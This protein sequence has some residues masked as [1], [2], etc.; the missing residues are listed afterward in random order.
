MTVS[1]RLMRLSNRSLMA[2]IF[3]FSMSTTCLYFIYVAPGIDYPDGN[4][5]SEYIAQPT[6][7]LPE[8]FT[9]AQNLPCP[10]RLPSMS[11]STSS[12]RRIYFK[13][14]TDAMNSIYYT[15][16]YL[17][18]NEFFGGVSGLTVEQFLKINGFPNAF[19]GWG[20]EDDDLWNRVHYAGFNVTRP[21]GDI[22]KYKSIPHHHRGEV[23]FLGR[24]KLLRYSKERQHLD[25]LNNLQ[26]SPEISLSSLYKNITV[27]LNPE[28]AP[29][30]EY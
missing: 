3:F 29:I 30:A 15:E 4:N 13:H 25:G 12:H 24:Y 19:W 17:P 8:N 16:P 2:F 7:Y 9:Y 21:E 28:L 22:G 11:K 10:E 26:Y 1:P 6:T 23:Q 14:S 5:S 18:Y 27:N 20:G